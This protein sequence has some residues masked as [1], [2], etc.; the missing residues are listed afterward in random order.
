MATFKIC[1]Y[2]HQKRKTD[3]KYPVSIRV[4]WKGKYAY[5]DTEYYASIE[6]IWANEKKG[7]F[8][9]K[10]PH[11]INELTRRIKTCESA[12]V[13]R[14]GVKIY[15][16]TAKELADYFEK[17]IKGDSGEKLKFIAFGRKYQKR[18]EEEGRS[19]DRIKTSLNA[20]E[21]FAKGDIYINE[22]TAKFLERF[23]KYLLSDRIIQRKNQFGK[24]VISHR[25]PVSQT[26]LSDYMTDIRTVF[27]E[28]RRMYNDED[29]G[30]IVIKHY[31]FKKYKVP[32]APISKKRNIPA[33]DI[34]SVVYT[35]DEALASEQAIV[36]RDVFTLSFLLVGMNLKDI[37]EITPDSYTDGRLNY[38]RS[39][40]KRRRKDNAF[41]SVK[42]EEEAKALIEKYRDKSGKRLFDFYTRFSTVRIFRSSVN[43]GLKKVAKVCNIDEPLSS[44]YARHSWATIARNKCRIAK[45]DV[46]ECLNHVDAANRMADVYIE[47]DW[48]FIDEANRKVIDFVFN[49]I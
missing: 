28:A 47:K 26:T 20:L 2:R 30:D 37:Y 48:S 49:S 9:L 14:L 39:K 43:D 7:V 33:E 40:T 34:L 19:F 5:I 38:E 35:T 18:L 44:Y 11:I 10:D 21:D 16:Y 23:E 4:Y 12:K 32:E 24:V 22:L 17:L 25:D 6:Q 3:K 27:N 46:D 15:Q 41:I 8:E 13:E 29:R 31:P 45:S 42:V 36:A 1:V